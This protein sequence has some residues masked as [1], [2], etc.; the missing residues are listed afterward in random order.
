MSEERRQVLELLANGKI[1]AEQAERLLDKLASAQA[2]EPAAS[3]PGG[4]SKAKPKFLCVVVDGAGG[5]KVNVRVPL[6]LVRS[7]IKLAAVLPEGAQAK[8]SERGLDLGQLSQLDADQ[9]VEALRELQV[10]VDSET[11]DTVRVCCE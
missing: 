1:T 5:D 11:G 8:L 6:A 9:L 2:K 10:D 7:G 3:A 4:E